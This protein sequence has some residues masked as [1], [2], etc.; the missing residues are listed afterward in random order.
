MQ[1]NFLSFLSFKNLSQNW[2]LIGLL[3][4]IAGITG[5]VFGFLNNVQLWDY[6]WACPVVAIITGFFVLFK[7]RF[8]M[9]SAIVWIICAPLLAVS[10]DIKKALQL[11]HI[12]HI[13]SVIV[14]IFILYHIKECWNHRGFLFGMASFYAYMGIT[15][16][17]SSGKI[18][19]ACDWFGCGKIILYLG[20]FFTILSF[21][22]LVWE[23]Y[24]K[25]LFKKNKNF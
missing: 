1:N 3:Q 22:L 2:H 12:H 25:F 16:Y 15:S 20:I 19:L 7:N 8:G 18:N 24:F 4:I 11:W 13:V 9:S 10:Y 5:Y 6:L 23:T 21:A 14:L 17:A